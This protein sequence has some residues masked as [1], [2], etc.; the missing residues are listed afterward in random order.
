[1][2]IL[3]ITQNFPS[4]AQLSWRLSRE[5]SHPEAILIIIENSYIICT[6]LLIFVLNFNSYYSSNF[7]GFFILAICSSLKWLTSQ[8]RFFFFFFKEMWIKGSQHFGRYTQSVFINLSLIWLGFFS[9][10][11]CFFTMI[12]ENVTHHL[13]IN[14]IYCFYS[15]Q[16]YFFQTISCIITESFIFQAFKEEV[17]WLPTYFI[18]ARSATHN[19]HVTKR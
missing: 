18:T 19:Q 4:L 10:F 9:F 7:N 3:I 15:W 5:S 14:K 11:S 13:R 1:M 2:L 16:Y 8:Q 17:M 6:A 12:K